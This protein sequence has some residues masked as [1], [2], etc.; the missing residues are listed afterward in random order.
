MP[1]PW[2]ALA[3]TAPSPGRP[4]TSSISLRTSSGSAAGRS[5]LL[6]TGMISRSAS[7]AAYTLA[8][9]CASMPWEAST[10]STAPSHAASERDTS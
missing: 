2:R 9:V 8:S 1:I 4:M 6:I 10:T 7:S 5:I 3:S